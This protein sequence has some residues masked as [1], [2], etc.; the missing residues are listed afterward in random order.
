MNSFSVCVGVCV[1]VFER[2]RDIERKRGSEPGRDFYC[3]F[4]M[5]LVKRNVSL[6]IISRELISLQRKP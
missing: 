2:E 4:P 3:S 5:D 1:C 6:L